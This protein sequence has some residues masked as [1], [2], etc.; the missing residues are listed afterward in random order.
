LHAVR[1]ELRTE[2]VPLNPNI[3][4]RNCCACRDYPAAANARRH[5]LRILI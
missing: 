1:D 4:S 5:H 2:L 3:R